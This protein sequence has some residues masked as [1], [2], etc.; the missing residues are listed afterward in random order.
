MSS[1]SKHSRPRGTPRGAAGPHGRGVAVGIH[2]AVVAERNAL[3][4]RCR[5]A[6]I[7]L[8]AVL[9]ELGQRGDAG[10]V[11]V[12]VRDVTVQSMPQHFTVAAE[13]I[14]GGIRLELTPDATGA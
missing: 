13:T 12:V 2:N 11:T 3:R 9:W 5:Q 14:E 4:D 6:D 10:V 8:G 7:T 1:K